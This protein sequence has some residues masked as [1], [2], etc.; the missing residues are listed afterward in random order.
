MYEGILWNF[1]PMKEIYRA[2]GGNTHVGGGVHVAQ[3]LLYLSKKRPRMQ[4]QGGLLDLEKE[5]F[6][7]RGVG[8][9][10]EWFQKFQGD[11]LTYFFLFW[12]G[13]NKGVS[14]YEGGK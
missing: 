4:P 13:E 12:G 11:N 3:A 1:F 9:L 10:I 5:S 14:K 8:G 7:W 6:F 2:W